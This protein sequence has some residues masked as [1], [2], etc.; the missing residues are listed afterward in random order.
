MTKLRN[1]TI[2]PDNYRVCH[3][4]KAIYPKDPRYN[5]CPKCQRTTE[6]IHL[7]DDGKLDDYE[8]ER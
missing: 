1:C 4:C 2:N 8:M 7:P 3:A 5:Q 6:I